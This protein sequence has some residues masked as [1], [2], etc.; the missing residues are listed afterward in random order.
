MNERSKLILS[1]LSIAYELAAMTQSF[2][3]LPK[4]YKHHVVGC[5][6]TGVCYHRDLENNWCTKDGMRCNSCTRLFKE[7]GVY[8]L[9]WIK[10]EI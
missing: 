5:Q 3:E 6:T 7:D 2:E 8:K 9:G 1:R 4:E 10:E